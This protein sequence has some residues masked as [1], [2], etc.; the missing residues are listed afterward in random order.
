MNK[1]YWEERYLNN[2]TGWDTGEISTPLKEYIN[3]IEDK[4]LNILIPGAGNGYEFDYL[5]EKGFSNVT[6]IDIAKRPLENLKERN[7]NYTKNFIEGDFFEFNETYDLIIEQTFFCALNPELRIEYV[8]KMHSLLNENGKIAG[9][10]FDF[11][12]TEDGPPFGGS[13]KEYVK[14]FSQKFNLKIL[15]RAYNSIK[16]RK[17]R[18]LFFIFEKK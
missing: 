5:I 2:E 6:V 11:P 4:S 3:Q 14:L 10:L 15:E 1:E 13:K 9:L 18:E 8:S 12:L 7:P 17:D 16:P